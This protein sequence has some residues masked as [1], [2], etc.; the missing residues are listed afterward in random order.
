MK[1]LILLV[2]I[3]FPFFTGCSDDG[4]T[5][6][7][8]YLPNY[9]FSIDINMELPLY[10]QLQFPSN[11]VLI[12]QAGIG[13]NGVIV[14]NTGNNYVAYEASC[15]NQELS[16]CSAMTINGIMAV[17]PCDE[18]EYGLLNGGQSAGKKYTLKPYRVS[19]SGPNMIR[20]YN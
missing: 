10:S 7:N 20:V 2:L 19:V 17:C 16:P 6:N 9:N 3:A 4:F 12:N 14:M 15:P 18:A 11:P 5:N 8:P 1:K 13:I